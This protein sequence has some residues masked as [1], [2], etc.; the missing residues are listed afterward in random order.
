[1]YALNQSPTFLISIIYAII[2]QVVHTHGSGNEWDIVNEGRCDTN[3]SGNNILVGQVVVEEDGEILEKAGFVKDSNRHKNAKEEKDTGGVKLGEGSR[4][5][6]VLV[7]LTHVDDV[8]EGP[9]GAKT[10]EL[11]RLML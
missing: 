9:D 5:L 11:K 3:D 8:S 7:S 4:D 1:M 6:L 10:G 2:G